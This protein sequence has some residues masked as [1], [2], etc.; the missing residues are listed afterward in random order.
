MAGVGEIRYAARNAAAGSIAL[1]DATPFMRRGGLRVVAP[2]DPVL[3]ALIV[4]LHVEFSI[5]SGHFSRSPWVL[6][7]WRVS[8]PRGAALGLE[9][10]QSGQLQRWRDER[11][12]VAQVVTQLMA[13]PDAGAET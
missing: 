1:L 7:A 9:L 8:V 12:P 11:T 3:E 13:P 5:I 6:E 10:A 4:A 2:A